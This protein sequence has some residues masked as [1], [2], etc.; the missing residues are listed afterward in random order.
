[1]STKQIADIAR[2]VLGGSFELL[3]ARWGEGTDALFLV[4][5]GYGRVVFEVPGAGLMNDAELAEHLEGH[6]RY[7]EENIAEWELQRKWGHE[8]ASLLSGKMK[9][10][11]ERKLEWLP[12][13]M[14][15]RFDEDFE[16]EMPL[17]RKFVTDP[18]S[19]DRDALIHELTTLPKTWS[20]Q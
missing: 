19:V 18:D 16:H 2:R 14:L 12:A 11:P 8:I 1:M 10:G 15:K 6:K 5:D 20:K 17:L 4:R 13:L 9:D 7:R 3:D